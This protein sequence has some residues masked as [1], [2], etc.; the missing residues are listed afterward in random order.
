M[1]DPN[2]YPTYFDTY[3]RTKNRPFMKRKKGDVMNIGPDMS[4]TPGYVD[5]RLPLTKKY[6]TGPLNQTSFV[7]APTKE[8]KDAM[9]KPYSEPQKKKYT[10][11]LFPTLP[12]VSGVNPYFDYEKLDWQ[13]SLDRLGKEFLGTEKGGTGFS[14]KTPEQGANYKTVRWADAGFKINPDQDVTTE[15]EEIYFNPTT[16]EVV[17][18]PHEGF[19]APEGWVSLNNVKP[20]APDVPED[21]SRGPEPARYVTKK[22]PYTYEDFFD[23]TGDG[24]WQMETVTGYRD[25]NYDNPAWTMWSQTPDLVRDQYEQELYEFEK[26]MEIYEE[27]QAEIDEFEDFD[28]EFQ[29]YYDASSAI[30]P[31]NLMDQAM[32]LFQHFDVPMRIDPVSGKLVINNRMINSIDD[33]RNEHRKL[34]GQTGA[35]TFEVPVGMDPASFYRKHLDFLTGGATYYYPRPTL[36]NINDIWGVQQP[37]SVVAPPT[38]NQIIQQIQE[39]EDEI[40]HDDSEDAAP[41]EEEQG[42]HS[43]AGPDVG[44]AGTAEDVGADDVGDAGDTAGGGAEGEGDDTGGPI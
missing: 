44:S 8:Q 31:G 25:V 28:P 1:A 33:L 12:S 41:A 19:V 5:P 32:R 29:L 30:D 34:V 26:S 11:S 27:R 21:F 37:E 13:K 10:D 39:E 40:V 16:R 23:A 18:A 36:R 17:R 43:T 15:Q 24:D 4:A 7:T 38:I 20:I 2:I 14:L 6:V 9:Y 42:T 22:E 3:S 35:G